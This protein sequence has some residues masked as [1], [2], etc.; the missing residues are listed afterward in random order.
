MLFVARLF[1]LRT[2]PLPRTVNVIAIRPSSGDGLSAVLPRRRPRNGGTMPSK[3]K[4]RE[5]TQTLTFEIYDLELDD[6]D[7]QRM[8]EDPRGFFTSL[9]EEEGQVVNDLLVAA[10]EKFL[11]PDGDTSAAPGGT[12]V[13]TPTTWHCTSPPDM[14]SK[15]ITIIM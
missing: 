12:H 14:R 1:V 6:Y 5:Q 4:K 13:P 9:L 3:L 10:D 11:A 7:R 15:W 2:D 8:A